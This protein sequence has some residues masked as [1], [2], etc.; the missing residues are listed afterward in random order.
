MTSNTPKKV[1]SKLSN[2]TLKQLRG[3]GHH[4]NPIITI[5]TAKLSDSLVEETLRALHDHELIKIKLPAGS[6]QERKAYA[7]ALADATQSTVVHHI[8]RMALLFCKNAT[9]NPKLSNLSRFG[10]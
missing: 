4:L 1:G 7:N 10:L 3:I 5:G 2:D 8:G 9:P 6:A